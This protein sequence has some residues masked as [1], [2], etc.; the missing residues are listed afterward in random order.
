M[1][2]MGSCSPFTQTSSHLDLESL[3]EGGL[4]PVEVLISA[5]RSEIISM[6][7]DGDLAG[8]MVED[9]WVRSA[10]DEPIA[11]HSLCVCILC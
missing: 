5:K 4:L 3:L 2:F 6:D 10:G 1:N 9:T 8:L 11:F 7:D